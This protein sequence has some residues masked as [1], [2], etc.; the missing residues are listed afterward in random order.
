MKLPRHQLVEAIGEK[1]FHVKDSKALAKA[2]AAYLLD[3]RRVSELDS[4][5]RD[6]MQYRLDRGWGEIDI[7]SAHELTDEV[8]KDAK[9]VLRSEHATAK[10]IKVDS[11]VDAGLIGGLKL[12]LPNEQLDMSVKTRLETFKK[13]VSGDWL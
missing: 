1:T 11:R 7:T 10:H 4:I 8:I 12:E 2:I 9:D 6:V 3:E 5:I 13:A